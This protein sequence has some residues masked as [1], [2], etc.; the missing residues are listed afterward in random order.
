MTCI[1]LKN[2]VFA[3]SP[4]I[5]SAGR[6]A[7]IT[8]IITMVLTFIWVLLIFFVHKKTNNQPLMEW[9]SQTIGNKATNF[10]ILL[11][12]LY[13]LFMCGISLRETMSWTKIAYLP[14][15]PTWI[16]TIM[17][18]FICWYLAKESMQTLNRINIFLLFF[19]IIFGFFV[20][21]ANIK[22]KNH[23]LLLPMLEHGIRPVLNGIIFQASG[24]V[25][26]FIFLLL[27]HK[28]NNPLKFRHFSITILLLTGLT[29]GPL[30]GALIEFGPR[31]A[32]IQRFPPFEEWAL[33][34]IGNFVEHVD[35]LSIY[36]WLSGV[37]IR[38]SLLL[39]LI[40]ELL[41]SSIQRK[42]LI[43][44]L[45]LFIIAFIVIVPISDFQFNYYLRTYILP[46]T[47]CFFF[48]FSI[49]ISALVAIQ[50]L[51]KRRTSNEV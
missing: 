42:N 11:F 30:I 13:L 2:H 4:L 39:F 50:T 29:L 33:V 35:F 34:S 18:L 15:T 7:W 44:F 9:L 21:T 8:V 25:E 31:E 40:K 46:T 49:L 23:S 22:F 3:I 26:I 24:M 19:I 48:S 10:V 1:G 17:F 43:L 12:V 6:D 20:A 38:I 5:S 27:Q 32:T 37:F 51:R 41:P 16:L 47:F 28:L 36:Q 45:F 14:E